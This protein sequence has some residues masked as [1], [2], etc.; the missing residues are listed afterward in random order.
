MEVLDLVNVDESQLSD[1][2]KL[3]R[4][5]TISCIMR[6]QALARR[7]LQ[8]SRVVK[9]IASRFEKIF[10]PNRKLYYYYDSLLDKS[11]WIK[12]KLLLASDIPIAP[13]YSPDEA[14]IR[15]QRQLWRFCALKRVRRI[16]KETITVVHDEST[17]DDYYYN[18]KSGATYWELPLFMG[19]KLV[20]DYVKKKKTKKNQNDGDISV[21]SHQ[22]IDKNNEIDD[23][24]DGDEEEG[25][26]EEAEEN[27]DDDDSEGSDSQD[28]D[29]DLDSV[30]LI[31]KRRSKRKYPRFESGDINSLNVISTLSDILLV[32]VDP[33]LKEL[34]TWEK[35]I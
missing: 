22:S 11:T 2:L 21:G 12:P 13:T 34:L 25:G 16:Y 19:G 15:I 26:G 3:K 28:S 8:R 7:F 29:D 17:G 4:E 32:D 33:K 14:A 9:G 10:D 23:D 31:E 27:V 18:P 1:E 20:H 24:D 30:Q 35:I 5:I 6:V